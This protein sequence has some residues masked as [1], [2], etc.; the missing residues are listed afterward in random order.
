MDNV[1]C[2]IIQDLLPLYAD[3]VVSPQSRELVE[4]H[5]C[6]CESCRGFLAQIR[7]DIP[8]PL[9]SD[10]AVLEKI[11]NV[12]RKKRLR[13][14]LLTALWMI[15]VLG[16]PL[17]NLYLN[18]LYQ[19]DTKH[20]PHCFT[21]SE[22]QDGR[23]ELLLTDEA[24]G[25][26]LRYLYQLNGDGTTD[27]YV[28]LQGHDPVPERVR[29]FVELL[30]FEESL[31]PV[32]DIGPKYNFESRERHCGFYRLDGLRLDETIRNVWYLPIT[33]E[34]QEDFYDH[35]LTVGYLNGYQ[36]PDTAGR[37]LIWTKNG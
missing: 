32:Y 25:A 16:W 21:V 5:L 11:S 26:R 27:L 34:Q 23:T 37:Q 29:L 30:F 28:C 6:G 9:A 1:H 20:G 2:N 24:F 19:P 36:V 13:A 4:A 22:A 33:Q 18:S 14:A 31:Y 7:E 8:V 35:Y 12:Q 17:L 15:L 3:D 10:E